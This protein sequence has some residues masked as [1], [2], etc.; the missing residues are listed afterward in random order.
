ML[1]VGSAKGHLSV[2]DAATGEERLSLQ[3]HSEP[4]RC[5]A[6]SAD[7]R[8]MA[9]GS[10]DRSWK[11]WDARTGDQ[12]ASTSGHDGK[13]GCCCDVN[14]GGR[15]KALN[16]KC[17]VVGHF[18]ALN[19]IAFATSG[20]RVATAGSDCLVILWQDTGAPVSLMAGHTKG[21]N[22]VAFSGDGAQLASGGDD[23][24]VRIWNA[25]NGDPLRTLAN[26]HTRGVTALCY[27]PCSTRLASA[28]GDRLVKVWDADY[29]EP[30]LTLEGHEDRALTLAFSPDGGTLASGGDDRSVRVW[31]SVS[32]EQR[33]F[34]R[35]HDGEGGCSCARFGALNEDCACLGHREAVRA[36]VLSPN[37]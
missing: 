2:M 23:R 13:N 19:A 25:F 36:V 10:W 37:P 5:V 16:K 15:C 31:D 32:G 17:E 1:A 21:V 30:L 12:I 6:L 9:S 33:L 24:S 14:E 7:G 22:I 20:A 29:W 34:L 28:G 8:T 27:S 18:M 26:A 11:L 35:G 4:V 3:G